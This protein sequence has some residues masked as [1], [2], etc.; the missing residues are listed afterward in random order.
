[1]MYKIINYLYNSFNLYTNLNIQE[2]NLDYSKYKDILE[3]FPL[4]FNNELDKFK[5]E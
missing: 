4:S 3:Y 5:N 1:M 2:I